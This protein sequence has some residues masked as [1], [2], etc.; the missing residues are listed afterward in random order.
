[1]TMRTYKPD[2]IMELA[3]RPREEAVHLGGTHHVT[4]VIIPRDYSEGQIV[5]AAHARSFA[6][7]L[8]QMADLYDAIWDEAYQKGQASLQ[9]QIDMLRRML[10]FTHMR[11]TAE[12]SGMAHNVREVDEQIQR[13]LGI[14][15]DDDEGGHR[16]SRT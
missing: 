4:G 9:P 15:E 1:M 3:D 6:A 14:Y 12:D 2:D 10:E 5:S 16:A 13:A 8:L 7:Q 11:L